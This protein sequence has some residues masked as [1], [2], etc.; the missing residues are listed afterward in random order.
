[1]VHLN[2]TV[3]ILDTNE[4]FV[5]SCL[6]EVLIREQDV[7]RLFSQVIKPYSLFQAKCCP[8]E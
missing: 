2:G 5:A 4:Y 7:I 6:G 1:M 8:F 3:T